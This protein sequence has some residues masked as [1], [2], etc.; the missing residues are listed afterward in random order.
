MTVTAEK[1]GRS[2]QIRRDRL[3]NTTATAEKSARIESKCRILFCLIKLLLN[4]MNYGNIQRHINT[5]K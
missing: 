1:R 5:F 4:N 2:D 3:A